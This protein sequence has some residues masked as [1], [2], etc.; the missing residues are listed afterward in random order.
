MAASVRLDKCLTDNYGVSRK[1]AGRIIRKGVVKVNDI[2]IKDAA[3]KVK[4]EDVIQCDDETLDV[5]TEE[6]KRYFM[7]N[8]PQGYVCASTDYQYPIVLSLIDEPCAYDLFCVGRL[9]LDTEGLL[10]I[11]DDGAWSHRITSP[12]HHCDKVYEVV[13]RDD[14]SGDVVEIFSKGILLKGE[15][16]ETKPA[17]LKIIEPRLVH[18]T[19]SEGKYHQ[20]KRM[21]ASVGNHVE[22]LKRIK[23]GDVALDENLGVGEYRELTEDEVMSLVK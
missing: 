15:K 4:P 20:V 3:Y 19:I 22:F 7:L 2:V 21:F 18:L 16:K 11:T 8:K 9:D 13:L 1:E 23:I 10:L 12:K 5:H 14:C 6:Q 17:T